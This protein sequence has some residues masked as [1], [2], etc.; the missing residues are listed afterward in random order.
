M[1]KPQDSKEMPGVSYEVVRGGPSDG[2]SYGWRLRE[3]N[4]TAL[5]AD[6]LG[7]SGF[8]PQDQG[9]VVEWL[10]ILGRRKTILFLTTLLGAIIGFLMTRWQVPVYQSRASLELQDVTAAFPSISRNSQEAQPYSVLL[11][12]QTQIRILQ[13]QS[14]SS[15][16][17]AKVKEMQAAGK[18]PRLNEA[19]LI[20]AANGARVRSAGETRI[21]EVSVDSPNPQLAADYANALATEFI[22]MNTEQRLK[23]NQR[24]R[25]WLTQQL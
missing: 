14:L 21:V 18:L 22:D 9:G 15:L 8:G 13:S 20:A 2:W 24:T 1:D 10:R 5:S 25:D 4:P 12:L 23:L 3:P 17:I 7:P 19:Q 16:A 11:D 6:N